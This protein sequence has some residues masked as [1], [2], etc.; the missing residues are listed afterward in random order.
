V[1]LRELEYV[2]AESVEHAVRALATMRGARILAGGQTL[3]NALKLR[4]VETPLLVDVSRLQELRRIS[5]AEDDSVSVGAAVTYD[6]FARSPVVRACHAVGA[7]MAAR[8]ADRQVRARGTVGGNVCLGDP[9]SNFPPLLV[10]IDAT[11]RVRGPAGVRDIAA[12]EFF[13]A[14]YMTAVGPDELLTEIVFPALAGEQRVAYESLQLGTDSWALARACA[15]VDIAD[16]IRAASVVL[17]C[18]SVPARQPAVEAALV[19]QHPTPD[20]VDNAAR[21]AG[22]NFDPPSDVHASTA[23]RRAMARVMTRRALLSATNR[24]S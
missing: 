18:G 2:R 5:I 22:D 7:E 13:V 8:I 21:L 20:V 1:L 12:A 17:G 16:T 19:G 24:E 3:L 4:L 14:P 11:L 9:T 15:L 6:E 10:A 23:Y